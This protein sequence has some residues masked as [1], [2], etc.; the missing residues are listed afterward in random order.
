[1]AAEW[2]DVTGPEYWKVWDSIYSESDST[3]VVWDEDAWAWPDYAQNAEFFWDY[4]LDVMPK[5]IRVTIELVGSAGSA[6]IIRLTSCHDDGGGE[7]YQTG[8]QQYSAPWGGIKSWTVD[9]LLQSVPFIRLEAIL[10][11]Y[12]A[13]ITK[14]EFFME[15][16][17]PPEKRFWT[18]FIGSSET[19]TT[20]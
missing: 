10:K 11:Y 18:N 14:I 6:S 4:E 19:G 7:Q 3:I 8:H 9:S 16:I 17:V 1:M 5:E 20:C 13:R 12:A 2:I 15:P